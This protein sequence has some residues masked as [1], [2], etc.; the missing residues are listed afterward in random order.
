M[1][2]RFF[3]AHSKSVSDE[4]MVEILANAAIVLNKASKGKPYVMTTGRDFF[5]R[6][7]KEVGSWDAWTN[8][9]VTGVDYLTREPHFHG[10]LVPVT[11]A[12]GIGG[13]TARIVELAINARRPI[14][15]FDMKGRSARIVNVKRV[16]ARDFQTGWRLVVGSDFT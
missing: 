13:A 7:F 5:E 11:G 9:V 2:R 15:A 3:I 6:K 1:E 16:N 8:L 4:E 14:F 12:D 10:F